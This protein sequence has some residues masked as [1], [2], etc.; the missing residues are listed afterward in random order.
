MD[1]LNALQEFRAVLDAGSF[2]GAAR[3][4]GKGRSAVQKQMAALENQLG[5]QLL[6]RSTR[7]LTPTQAGLALYERSGGLLDE[8]DSLLRDAAGDAGGDPAGRLRINAPVSFGT[9]RL[10][11]LVADF[12]SRHPRLRVELALNDRFIDPVEEGYDLTI[13]I[14]EPR[15]LTSLVTQELAAV[16]RRL[17][18]APD[19]LRSH[20]TPADPGELEQHDCLQYGPLAA[21]SHWRL[22]GPAAELAVPVSCVLWSNNGEVL[23]DAALAGRGIALLPDFI[24]EAALSAGRLVEVLPAWRPADLAIHALYPRH[25]HLA[26][27]VRQLVNH[28]REA[29]AP[30]ADGRQDGSR[31]TVAGHRRDE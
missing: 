5:T 9:L 13:R 28:L 11:P 8:L 25:R 27:S 3:R 21:T 31:S 17:C 20:G 16:R 10:S 2:A 26:T 29:L 7:R 6:I 18:A 12:A 15:Y 4:L 30:E 22:G 1:L 24:A 23:R 14:A 19:Y